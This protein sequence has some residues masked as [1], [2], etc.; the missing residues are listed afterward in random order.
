MTDF[1]LRIVQD[2]RDLIE[3]VGGPQSDDEPLEQLREG[4][5]AQQLQ[6]TFLCLAQQ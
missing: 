6:L 5:G 3:L 4:A 1:V 2:Q